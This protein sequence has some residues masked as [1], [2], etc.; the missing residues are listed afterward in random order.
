MASQNNLR[1]E[2]V[3]T[4]FK[5]IS[6]KALELEKEGYEVLLGYEE[7][8]GFSVLNLVRDKDGLSAAATIS[9]LSAHL[10]E[11]NSSL[12]AYLESI[13]KK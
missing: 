4:G 11:Q 2:E 3:L 10:Y 8:I 9:Q 7:A 13:Y 6:N 12:C 5:W 1:F